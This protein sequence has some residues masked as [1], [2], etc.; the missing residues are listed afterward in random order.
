MATDER[1]ESVKE[2]LDGKTKENE[3]PW[4]P[5]LAQ[6]RP[7]CAWMIIRQIARPRPE[8]ERSMVS[9]N[10]VCSSKTCSRWS[11]LIPRPVS[12]NV[13]AVARR[14]FLRFSLIQSV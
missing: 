3:A 14:S 11:G 6:M 8:P 13:D 12:A 4:D 5:V 2:R 1:F 9:P 10:E 7:W